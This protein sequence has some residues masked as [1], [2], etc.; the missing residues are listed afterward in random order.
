MILTKKLRRGLNGRKPSI[1]IKTLLVAD[2]T[3]YKE[4]KKMK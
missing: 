3:R 1:Q 2:L 4:I